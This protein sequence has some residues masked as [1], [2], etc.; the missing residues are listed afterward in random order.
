MD[1]LLKSIFRLAARRIAMTAAM[2]II[3]ADFVSRK[4]TGRTQ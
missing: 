1:N 2:E 3:F 4:S